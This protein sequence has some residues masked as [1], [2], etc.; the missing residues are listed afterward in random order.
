M[1]ILWVPASESPGTFDEVVTSPMLFL[2]AWAANSLVCLTSSRSQYS[3][4]LSRR[5]MTSWARARSAD[6]CRHFADDVVP[7]VTPAD[8][9][10]VM[11]NR[12]TLDRA[13]ILPQMWRHKPRTS[14]LD[15]VARS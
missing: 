1:C 9:S 4:R 15:Q 7:T 11:R 6:T 2:L 10:P 12:G 5:V 3:V 14:W 8:V 13:I